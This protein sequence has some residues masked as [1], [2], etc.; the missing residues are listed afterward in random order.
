MKTMK[1]FQKDCAIL[2]A[3]SLM[4]GTVSGYKP[5][6]KANVKTAQIEAT[7]E[8][9]EKKDAQETHAERTVTK[10]RNATI[11]NLGNG[12]KRAEFYAGDIRFADEN[13]ELQDYDTSLV[14]ADDATGD[15]MYETAQSDKKSYF[16]EK[17]SEETPVL[18]EYD[19]YEVSVSSDTDQKGTKTSKKG[20]TDTEQVTDLYAKKEEKETSIEYQG[21]WE[22]ASL[23]YE[24]TNDGLKESIILDDKSAPSRYSFVFTMKNCCVVTQEQLMKDKVEAKKKIETAEGEAL[25]LYDVAEEKLVGSLP[26]G[27]MMDSAGEYS[28]GCSYVLKLKSEKNT[29]AE[30]FHTYEMCLK[31]DEDY[32]EAPERKY[33]VTI[34]PSITWSSTAVQTSSAYVCRTS[35]NSTYTDENTNILCVGKRDTANDVC[36]AYMQFAG[37]NETVLGK[38]VE[39]A[40]MTIHTYGATTG[41]PIYV[42]N[43]TEGWDASSIT[44]ANQPEKEM[45]VVAKFTTTTRGQKVKIELDANML[46]HR[47]KGNKGLYGFEFTD[48]ARDSNLTSAKTTWIYNSVSVNSS[49][50][51]KLQVTYHDVDYSTTPQLRYKVFQN[52]SHWSGFSEDGLTAGALEAGERFRAIYMNLEENGY[53]TGCLQYRVCFE[54]SGWTSWTSENKVSGNLSTSERMKAIQIRL[55]TSITEETLAVN[56][57]VY[58]RV[59]TTRSGWLGWAKNGA[60]A[61]DY[62]EGVSV[63]GMQAVVVPKLQYK[64]WYLSDGTEI[65]D[66][67]EQNQ[68]LTAATSGTKITAL[69]VKTKDDDFGDDHGV[70][71]QTYSS[72]ATSQSL[73]KKNHERIGDISN[74]PVNGYYVIFADADTRAKYDIEHMA[75]VDNAIEE[76]RWKKNREVSGAILNG[77]TV[78]T[79]S[80]RAVPKGYKDGKRA[81]YSKGFVMYED[82]FSFVNRR[83]DFNYPN[84][85]YISKDKVRFV[86]GNT[87][88]E[89]WKWGGSCYGM[90]L[91]S[92]L[93]SRG[94][95][96]PSDFVGNI[97]EGAK[98]T[99]QLI[100]PRGKCDKKCTDYIEYLHVSQSLRYGDNE[101]WTS[102]PRKVADKLVAYAGKKYIMLL[103][104][105]KGGHAVVPLGATTSDGVHY[106]VQLYDVNNPNEIMTAKINYANNTFLYEPREGWSYFIATLGD[107]DILM[108]KYGEIYSDI[109]EKVKNPNYQRTA[110]VTEYQSISVTNC[111]DFSIFDEDGIDISKRNDVIEILPVGE[112]GYIVYRVPSGKYKIVVNN[113]CE[114]TRI[115]AFTY[116]AGVSYYPDEK[117]TLTF[118][119]HK[120]KTIDGSIVFADEEKHDFEVKTFDKSNNKERKSVFRKGLS[121]HGENKKCRI[122]KE[123]EK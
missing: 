13:G 102:D 100:V 10:K 47:V 84:P 56:Y 88:A 116:E 37:L 34:E 19:C 42:R 67:G 123:K 44:Y 7:R 78:E 22:N 18:T 120:D 69:S 108:K 97:D 2:L 91:A 74:Y 41:M 103:T 118:V 54:N 115:S 51:P 104:S 85:Y 96:N 64:Q 98:T 117:S 93:F 12:K 43:V 29:G 99:S 9:Q 21:I 53:N 48:S 112:S 110:S 121:L 114:E 79:V 52:E 63:V 71:I 55:T 73:I 109:S 87:E 27:Y 106:E 61:G 92:L 107:M 66:I 5:T 3:M 45:D 46:H 38:Y 82:S 58:Y 77:S 1:R 122:G 68:F 11:Y 89:D 30:I 111:T 76:E 17:I 90:A 20:K 24:S 75:S 16:P 65:N 70:S 57:D 72:R 60:E 80:V 28:E 119:I 62:Q 86:L 25:Y 23:E 83:S 32:L 94:A 81:C 33:P 59:Y 15:Y 95:S 31:A 101:G 8:T 49:K 6:A 105:Y 50:I 26:A 4:L 36:R 113:P 40:T 39:E 35:P 14:C